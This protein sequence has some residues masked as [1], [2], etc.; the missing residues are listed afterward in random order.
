EREVVIDL[1]TSVGDRRLKL[2]PEYRVSDSASLRA[3]LA[4]LLG[5]AMLPG[6]DTGGA[7]HSVS[8]ES[9]RR[10]ASVV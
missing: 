9:E 7:P 3:E 1:S 6:G 5:E 4:D 10:Q 8:V 2:G